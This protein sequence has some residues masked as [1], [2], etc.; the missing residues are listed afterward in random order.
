MPGKTGRALRRWSPRSRRKAGACGGTPRSRPARNSIGKSPP[1]SMR[2]APS[3]SCGRRPRSNRAGCAAR[4]EAADR[5]AL[6]PVRFDNARLPIDARRCIPPTWTTGRRSASLR[7]RSCARARAAVEA[8]RRWP[9]ARPRPGKAAERQGV[10]ICVLP[11]ANMS[12]D[13]EQEY[14][15]DGISEDVITDLSKVSALSVISRNTAFMFKAKPVDVPQ[16]ARQL[17]VSYVLE[18][19]VRKSGNRVRITAQLIDG[20]TDNHVW[21]DRYDRDLSDIFALQDEISAGDRQSAEAQAAARGKEGDRA[22]RHDQS[23]SVRPLSDGATIQRQRQ[24]GRCS[25]ERGHHSPV[26]PRHEID[27]NMRGRGRSSPTRKAFADADRARRRRR[28]GGRPIARS[29]LDPT[30]AEAHAAK[31]Q[32]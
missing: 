2:P 10:S 21:A 25:P 28:L 32:V 26:P 1:S 27:P 31:A 14:F 30:L 15:T 3:S 20:A 24:S 6:V 11:F 18:G 7:F 5:G 4:R 9:S 19:S 8:R 17:Q 29:A 13:A 16:V 12:G 22:A 23:R